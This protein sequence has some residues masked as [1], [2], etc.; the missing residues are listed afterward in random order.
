MQKSFDDFKS[1]VNK[2]KKNMKFHMAML[3]NKLVKNYLVKST[4]GKALNSFVS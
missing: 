3:L 4:K 2:S 1:K